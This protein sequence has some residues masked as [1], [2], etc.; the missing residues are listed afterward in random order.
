M[1]KAES[2]FNKIGSRK[3]QVLLI[4][5]VLFLFRSQSFT[6]D[7]MVILM[8]VYMGVNVAGKFANNNRGEE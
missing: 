5:I 7:H 4:G 8:S 6:G 2:Y 1:K 3:F